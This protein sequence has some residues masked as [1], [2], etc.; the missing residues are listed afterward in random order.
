MP[1]P[2]CMPRC[3]WQARLINVDARCHRS[4]RR[5][6]AVVS[7]RHFRRRH[8][9]DRGAYRLIS[10][11]AREVGGLPPERGTRRVI[12]T[13]PLTA[14]S[15]AKRSR[16]RPAGTHWPFSMPLRDRSFRH[17]DMNVAWFQSRYVQGRGARR[18]GRTTTSTA[19]GQGAVRRPVS[20]RLVAGDKT[21]SANGK[22]RPI[23]R[24][25]CP[26]ASRSWRNADSETLRH[27]PIEADGSHNS[28]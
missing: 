10:I 19:D 3:G 2:W 13:G 20:R 25:A 7:A 11:E 18:H 8:A 27:G 6:A 15:L 24:T 5:G 1:S 12:A 26:A 22:A 23:Y 9:P 21:P 4:G 28:A 17:D 14:L 16:R